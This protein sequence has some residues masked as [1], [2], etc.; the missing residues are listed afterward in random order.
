MAQRR[1]APFCSP[2]V[3]VSMSFAVLQLAV[4]TAANMPR[5]P[6]VNTMNITEFY[7]RLLCIRYYDLSHRPEPTSLPYIVGLAATAISK[8]EVH[9][10]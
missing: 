1:V 8:G 4:M 6:A 9:D 10:R 2:R 5:M 7:T 3:D